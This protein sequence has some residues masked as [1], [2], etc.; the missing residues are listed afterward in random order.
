MTAKKP[1]PWPADKI[2]RRKIDKL[3]PYAN[4]ARTHSDA[5]V[6]QIVAS[7]KE[8]GWTN[9]VLIEKSGT[10][11]AGHGRVL[12]ARQ[13]GVDEI[14]VMIATGWSKAQIKAY[15]L[16][17]NQLALNA[18]WDHDILRVELQ[19]LDEFDVS[20]QLPGFSQEFM[21]Q[22][23]FDPNF[24]P[25]SIDDQGRLDELS[26]KMVECPHCGKSYDLRENGQ[27]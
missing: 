1:P 20:F 13:L 5:Q 22:L 8:W 9:P 4:N 15:A 18:D 3:I 23:F 12:A 10:I 2:E 11:I 19:G 6:A 17:D 16:A 21:D 7:M 27:G 24:E 26:P 14:P 25:G